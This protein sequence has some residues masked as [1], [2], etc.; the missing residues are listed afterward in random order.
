MPTRTRSSAGLA[1]ALLLAIPLAAGVALAV[2][3]LAVSPLDSGAATEAVIASVESA[4]RRD[5]TNVTATYTDADNF[6][7]NTQSSGT[8]TALALS[9]GSE[10]KQGAV[11]MEVDGKPVIVYVATAPL[12]RDIAREMEGADVATA[13]QL[14]FDLG[15]LDGVDGKAGY[16]T[17]RAIKAFNKDHGYGDANATLAVSSL[18]WT[19]DSSD[20]PTALSVRVGDVLS[21]GLE[22]YTTTAGTASY[23][24]NLEPTNVDRI[25]TLNELT[26]ELPAGMTQITDADA[27]AALKARLA[28]VTNPTVAVSL[29]EPRTVGPIP[30]SAILSDADG[31]I[32]FFPGMGDEPIQVDVAS[33]SMG[34]VDVNADFIGQS[35]LVN[36]REVV[37][38]LTCDS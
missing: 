13:Q 18:L 8:V 31:T 26:I 12:Y 32:C 28:N 36:P 24:L 23:S 21:P 22:L 3:G 10:A 6:P 15:Y 5:T 9:T 17:E 25:V 14:L 1:T 33:G 37:D 29:A 11:A 19:P 7:V 27:V 20:A 16:A 30:A 4:Q 35:V 34:L 2:W 38:D